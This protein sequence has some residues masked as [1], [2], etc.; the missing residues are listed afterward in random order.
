[1]DHER[2]VTITVRAPSNDPPVVDAGDD[3]EVAHDAVVTLQGSAS[4]PEDDPL[5]Y[6]WTQ[7][8]GPAAVIRDPDELETVVEGLHADATLTFRLTVTDAR[9]LVERR[10]DRGGSPKSRPPRPR[11]TS[12]WCGGRPG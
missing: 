1:M 9:R 5:T 10:G 2:R 4:D 11:P 3:Q 8:G 7:V 6:A 12:A